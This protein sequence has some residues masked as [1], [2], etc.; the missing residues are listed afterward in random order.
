MPRGVAGMNGRAKHDVL[1]ELAWL[2]GGCAA[3]ILVIG[4][5][6]AAQREYVATLVA[7]Q[8]QTDVFY[9]R[10]FERLPA[11]A[12]LLVVLDD[13]NGL[14]AHDQQRLLRWIDDTQPQIL[15]F[16]R[17]QLYPMVTAGR[18]RDAL[19]YRLNVVSLAVEETD[20]PCEHD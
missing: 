6:S 20:I 19:F 18:F 7:S 17:E 13:V 16:A 15:S 9:A 1:K 8:R 5:L 12:R 11:E 2:A 10:S 14:S 4:R 3:N